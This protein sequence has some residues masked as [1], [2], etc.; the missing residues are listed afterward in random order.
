MHAP[1]RLARE[2]SPYLLQHANNPVDWFPWGEEAFARAREQ[3]KPIFLSIGYSTCHW[4]HVMERESFEDAHIAELLN[5]H[6]V[7]IKVDRE[8]RP[9][10][11]RVYMTAMQAMRMGGGW[12]LNVFLTPQ[13]APFWGGTY[14]PPTSRRGMPGMDEILARIHGAWLEQREQIE[15]GGAQVL[16]LV[17]S[18]AAPGEGEEP[19]DELIA[20]CAAAL[21]RT[22]DAS[23]GGFGSAPKFPSTVNL[24]FLLR[25]WAA[26]PAAPERAAAKLMVLHQLEAM[27]AG[28]IHDQ[29][30]GGFHRYSTDREWL[31]PHFEKML[32][33]Q[34]LILDAYVDGWLVTH[35]PRWAEVARGIVTYVRRD[36][37]SDR[38]AFFC[39]EDADSEGEEGRF[40]VWTPAQ[41]AEALSPDDARVVAEHWGVTELGNFEHGTSILNLVREP[42]AEAAATLARARETLLAVR[43]KRVR[44]HLDDKVL[45]A[46]NGMMI[47]ALAR[48]A[49]ALNEPA[50][51]EAAVCSA[52]FVWDE[53]CDATSGELRRRWREGEAKGAGQLDDYAHFSRGCLELF[54][55]THDARWLERAVKLAD[56]MLA[57]LWDDE[58]GACFE[59][60]IAH[61]EGAGGAPVRMKDGFDGAETAG[62]SIS[63]HVL[64]RLA[65]LTD[66]EDL[67]VKADRTLDYHATRLAGSAWAMPQLV[68]A[69][70]ESA[71]PPSH[72]VIR[73]EPSPE[74]ESLLAVYDSR[75]R[76]FGDRI[77]VEDASRAAL[78]ALAPFAAS[79]GARDVRA[80]A[81]VCV[82]HRCRLPVQTPEELAAELDSQGEN[83]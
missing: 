76:P 82:H 11:D 3:D 41:L 26:A 18:L 55:T 22:H 51:T 45:A 8:E 13:L 12:P 66:R 46:W 52:E 27:R 33:D 4:C 81:Y 71:Q 30:G 38:G 62:N 73:G 1:N 15:A 36:L 10:V 61:S 7:C 23:E 64:L 57:R 63:A 60:P 40:Y 54:V 65:R 31:V 39:G 29:V 19:R 28:G 21:A 44:P 68:A 20:Q 5:A 79:L 78:A 24:H 14:F 49:R 48:G 43:S 67:Q 59:S 9:D 53:L 35:D 6:Y 75:F 72:V 25:W 80:T 17:A 69:M 37:T 2:K 56:A 42:S 77:V 74:R 50:W 58:H 32:Y 47:A 16:E 34:A 70:V 83:R